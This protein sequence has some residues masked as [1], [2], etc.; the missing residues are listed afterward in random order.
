[1]R[2]VTI[3]PVLLVEGRYTTHSYYLT[4][5]ESPDGARV[6]FFSSTD[7]GEVRMLERATGKETVLADKVYTKDAHCVACQRWRSCCK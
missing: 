7:L 4:N 1:M 3:K 2:D 5:P 6:L